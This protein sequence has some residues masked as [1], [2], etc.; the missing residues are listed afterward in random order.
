MTFDETLERESRGISSSDAVG[1][2]TVAGIR[3][4][5]IATVATPV[6]RTI[7]ADERTVVVDP[8]RVRIRVVQK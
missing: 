3:R 7:I 1:R 4:V 2:S 8:R 5:G 6:R